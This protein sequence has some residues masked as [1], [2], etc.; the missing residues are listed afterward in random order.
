MPLMSWNNLQL[1]TDSIGHKKWLEM[2]VLVLETT[3]ETPQA[4]ELVHKQ[5]IRN[6]H[7]YSGGIRKKKKGLN[8]LFLTNQTEY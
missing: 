8:W 5:S 1:L 6:N 3:P 2:G 4:R 7:I